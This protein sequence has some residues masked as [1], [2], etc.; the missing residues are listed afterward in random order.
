MLKDIVNIMKAAVCVLVIDA[1]GG[2]LGGNPEI[3]D[4]D[5]QQPPDPAKSPA[6]TFSITDAP[7]EEARHVYISVES[8]QVAQAEGSWISI[9]LETDA[10]IDLLQLQNG[11][12]ELLASIE[13]LPA[14]TYTQTRLIL[15]EEAPGRL[16]DNEGVEHSLVIP[17]GSESGLK[18]MTSF[19]KVDGEPMAFTIDF[20]LRKSI[21]SAGNGSKSKYL[22]KPVLRMTDDRKSGSAAGEGENGSVVCVYA[23]G[24]T[25][26]SD[27]SCENAIT[28]T[29]VKNGQ[30]KLAFLEPGT[31]DLRVFRNKT[32][33]GDV[34]DVVVKAGSSDNNDEDT[35]VK[36][37]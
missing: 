29:T 21:K 28:S 27:D 33:V 31:Y 19:T 9:P 5:S 2:T 34:D 37:P 13:D 18:L 10:E 1:C 35:K 16:V 22:L 24:A 15:A 32:A 14:G 26:D 36:L 6:L 11:A 12:T 8:I 20:D 23:D 4:P 7:V 25:K 3:T 30:F 17:S